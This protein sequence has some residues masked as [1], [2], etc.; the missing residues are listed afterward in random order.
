MGNLSFEYLLENNPLRALVRDHLEVRPLKVI[1]NIGN[2][3][4]ALHIACGCGDA[5]K[6]VRKHFKT[7]RISAID[8]KEELITLARKKYVSSPVDFY[9]Q[10]ARA[11]GFEDNTFDVVFDL[12]DLHNYENWGKCILE[13]NRVLKPN[14][15]FILEELSQESFSYSTG[16][17]F[18]KLTDHPYQTMYTMGEFC[19]EIVK[20]G[21]E[22][23]H[24]EEKRPFRFLKYFM[25]IAQ[26]K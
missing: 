24:F 10:D 23:L 12:A 22:V 15:L 14:G 1:A 2:I 13:I 7:K 8:Q 18:K 19:D 5:T 21:F 20:N 9:V 17:L 11:L 6:L 26:K 16:K 3:D 25:M 4:N